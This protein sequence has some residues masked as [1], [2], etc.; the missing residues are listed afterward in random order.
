ME[1]DGRNSTSGDEWG[2]YDGIAEE[3]EL[4]IDTEDNF[5]TNIHEGDQDILEDLPTEKRNLDDETHPDDGVGEGVT[6]DEEKAN[7]LDWTTE[8]GASKDLSSFFLKFGIFINPFA[9][10]TEDLVGHT[11]GFCLRKGHR[12]PNSD[13]ATREREWLCSREGTRSVVHTSR[14]D[15]VRVAKAET[16]IRCKWRFQF[17]LNKVIKKYVCR[18]FNPTHTHPFAEATH[19][20]FIRANRV[21]KGGF[22]E[23]AK[24]LKTSGVR[25]CHIMSYIADQ[26]G[27][28][29][30]V[31]FTIKDLYN[32]IK[33]ATTT[34]FKHKA[35]HDPAFYAK[36]SYDE[37]NRLLNVF[38]S[39]S[40]SRG[41]YG[42]YGHAIA[43][44]CTYKTNCYGKP[45]LIWVGIN[46]HYRTCP[47]GFAILGDE[48]TSNYIRA[49]KHFIK[50][51]NGI[52]LKTVVTDSDPSI[53]E[54]MKVAMPNVIHR[55][56]YWHLHNN[57]MKNCTDSGW[58]KELGQLVH[59][60]YTE[61]EF[62]EK[63]YAEA[64]HEY[65]SIHTNP[66]PGGTNMRKLVEDAS[67]L[68][69][70]NIFFKVKEQI[71]TVRKVVAVQGTIF[72]LTKY[73]FPGARRKVYATLDL[74]IFNCECQYFSSFGIPCRHIF[75]AMKCKNLTTIPR[76]LVLTRWTMEARAFRLTC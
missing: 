76:G 44:D 34:K 25:T 57:A 22:L 49:A 68:Y 10:K 75:A 62:S 16:R 28:Y 54:A 29:D 52:T 17:F 6:E 55:L 67:K 21:I 39:D 58:A 13:G 23:T 27:G 47:L 37:D 3:V 12:R 1:G 72:K 53:K 41:D 74:Q 73:D 18:D 30:K 15:R 31:P 60:Y 5:R 64:K 38:W 2:E 50:A 40:R 26:L 51:M 71:S 43:F 4:E 45:F 48:S 9:L 32:S 20:C 8:D 66:P 24:S 11:V 33:P 56:C 46:S 63:W 70:R 7:T 14:I 65:D 35:D 69:T 61:E 19:K 59:R 42:A 36:Y